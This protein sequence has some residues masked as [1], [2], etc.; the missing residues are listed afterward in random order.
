MFRGSVLTL[1]LRSVL[2]LVVGSDAAMAAQAPAPW[3]EYT[4]LDLGRL[5]G[6][7]LQKSDRSQGSRPDLRRVVNQRL[8]AH[9]ALGQS[10]HCQAQ[11]GAISALNNRGQIVGTPGRAP[12]CGRTESSR[13]LATCLDSARHG[14]HRSRDAADR[15]SGYR[16]A[17]ESFTRAGNSVQIPMPA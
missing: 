13:V 12:S 6:G 8:R 2:L 4:V 9:S 5:A 17:T 7:H 16:A 3:T 1:V 15:L 11:T 10:H 14:Q